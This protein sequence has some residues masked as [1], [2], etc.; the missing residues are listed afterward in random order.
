MLQGALQNDGFCYTA[1]DKRAKMYKI[2]KIEEQEAVN[3]IPDQINY[4]NFDNQAEI[5]ATFDPEQF[6][7]VDVEE[8]NTPNGPKPLDHDYTMTKMDQKLQYPNGY[9]TLDKDLIEQY[10]QRFPGEKCDKYMKSAKKSNYANPALHC[11]TIF[12]CKEKHDHTEVKEWFQT[13]LQ[14]RFRAKVL[15]PY[16]YLFGHNR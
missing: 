12:T 1:Q 10:K 8:P 16:G 3:N 9:Y 2:D 4:V 15:D 5:V 7:L 13:V 11:R 6:D 14:A